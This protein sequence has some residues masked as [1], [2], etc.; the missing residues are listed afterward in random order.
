MSADVGLSSEATWNSIKRL[1]MAFRRRQTPPAKEMLLGG[2]QSGAIERKLRA[3]VIR[4]RANGFRVFDDG[5]VV[6]LGTFRPL[7][8]V[9]GRACRAAAGKDRRAHAHRDGRG[10][11]PLQ[12]D[13]TPLFVT[14]A[15]R[16]ILNVNVLSDKPVFSLKLENWKVDRPP[17]LSAALRVRI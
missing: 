8:F 6:I 16:G 9:K 3:A 12:R 5:A 14:S 10:R 13:G 1:L 7:R 15:P 2:P 11:E 4:I 17:W